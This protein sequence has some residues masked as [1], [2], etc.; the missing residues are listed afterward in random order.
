LRHF[1]SLIS[2]VGKDLLDERETPARAL[3]EAASAIA[4]L[5]VGRQDTHTEQEPERV[6]K[7]MSFPA[8][9]F[10]TGVETLRID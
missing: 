6:D 2:G 10:L 9:D 1:R 8:D 4:I 5:N 3:Q 7:D